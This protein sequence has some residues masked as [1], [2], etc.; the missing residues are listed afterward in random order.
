MSYP[1]IQQ[2]ELAFEILARSV[3]EL[4]AIST[5]SAKERSAVET[6]LYTLKSSFFSEEGISTELQKGVLEPMLKIAEEYNN[7]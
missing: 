3:V 7:K 1:T 5:I 2:K 6:I 4:S